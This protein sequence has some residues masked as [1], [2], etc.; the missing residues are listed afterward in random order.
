MR[1]M[2]MQRDL[3]PGLRTSTSRTATLVRQDPRF[4]SAV[5]QIINAG[6]ADYNS[7]QLSLNK[8]FSHS[9]S[10]R[11]SYTR[12]KSYGNTGSPGNSETINTQVLDQ[13]NLDQNE[14]LTGEDRPHILSMDGSFMVPHTHGLMLSGVYQF[15]S[16]TPFTLTNSS[17][18][19]DRNGSFQEPLAAGT[20]TG[21]G[22][23]A[24]SVDYKGGVRG[25][26][27]PNYALLNMRAGWRFR[28]NESRY[29]Q[30][31]V[32]VFNVTNRENFSTP[33][34]DR[35]TAGTFLILRSIQNGGPTRTAQLNLKFTF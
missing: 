1:E 5:L 33:S 6:W 27:G 15:T 20:Y 8:R 3:N 30:A 21:T 28:L 7:L 34:G 9:H 4:T 13:L 14:G 11:V 22:N 25:A 19:P 24:Y 18:D 32:D 29:L 31:H 35:R 17:S 10:F 2:Y 23:N 12:S 16:G 26:R